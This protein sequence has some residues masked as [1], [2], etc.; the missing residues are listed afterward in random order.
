MALCIHLGVDD[1]A[2]ICPHTEV[3]A[4]VH[5]CDGSHSHMRSGNMQDVFEA[6]FIPSDTDYRMFSAA[7]G[8]L[9]QWPGLDIAHILDSATYHTRQDSLERLRSGILQ[10]C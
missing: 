8:Q 4:H 1:H 3:I 5:V 2:H 7:A 10:A 9:G 6:G